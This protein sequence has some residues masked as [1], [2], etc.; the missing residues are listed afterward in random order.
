MIVIGSGASAVE[1]LEFAAHEEAEKTYILA[2][3]NKWI[4]PRNPIADALLSLNTILSWI[5][6]MLLRK[7]F[8]RNLEDLAPTNKEPL[9]ANP[10]HIRNHRSSTSWSRGLLMEEKM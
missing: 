4:T 8:C 1:A 3:S 6:E 5:P 2:R 10:H 7:F 9:T